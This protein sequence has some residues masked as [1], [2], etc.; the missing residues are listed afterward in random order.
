MVFVEQGFP[1]WQV[2][3]DGDGWRKVHRERGFLAVWVSKDAELV[4]FRFGA[5]TAPRRIGIL[6]SLV[7]VPLSAFLLARRRDPVDPPPA[8][9]RATWAEQG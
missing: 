2:Q 3:V 6:L 9:V 8:T 7:V 1:G 4:E 5:Y